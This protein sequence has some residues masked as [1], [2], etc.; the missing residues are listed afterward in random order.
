M[1]S[2]SNLWSKCFLVEFP[3]FCRWT[4]G[5]SHFWWWNP[6]KYIPYHLHQESCYIM[7]YKSLC[8]LLKTI[9]FH[10][11]SWFKH[12]D[13]PCFVVKTPCFIFHYYDPHAAEATTRV[14]LRR[15]SRSHT[16]SRS[17]GHVGCS[18]T[19]WLLPVLWSGADGS[20]RN[21]PALWWFM[22]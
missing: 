18:S 1:C 21:H 2:I 7:L 13:T 8:L 4:N 14:S 15:S 17:S 22:G 6:M 9:M 20:K 19:E 16:S 3:R 11:C 10:H 12:I 5:K